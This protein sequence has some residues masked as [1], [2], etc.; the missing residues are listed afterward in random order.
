MDPPLLSTTTPL[1]APV[2]PPCPY[3]FTPASIPASNNT[4]AKNLEIPHMIHPQVIELKICLTL[5][6]RQ[7]GA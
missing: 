4:P 5:E 3:A 6:Q 1:M 2:A 7:S